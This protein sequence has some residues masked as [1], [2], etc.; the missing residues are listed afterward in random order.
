MPL[1][2]SN[3][4]GDGVNDILIR[5]SVEFPD[6]GTTVNVDGQVQPIGGSLVTITGNVT[7]P[8]API[9]GSIFYIIEANLTTGALT[10]VQNVS[11]V[12][13]ADPNNVTLTTQTLTPTTTDPALD[14]VITPDTY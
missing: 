13:S 8:A 10:V 2:I 12:P 3:S 11:G 6:S 5:A 14:P 7:I 4:T 1:T 9:S